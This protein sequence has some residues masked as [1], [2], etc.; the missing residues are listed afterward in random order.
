MDI[1]T[2]ATIVS[3]GSSLL[4]GSAASD[5]AKA[6]AKAI[7]KAA[8]E[9]AKISRYDSAV[10]EKDAQAIYNRTVAEFEQHYSN[11]NKL[12]SVQKTKYAKSG[13]S[14]GEGSPM[15]V[16]A[17][18]AKRGYLDGQTLLN[19]GK[20]AVERKKSLAQRYEM[21]ADAGLRDAAA[22]ASNIRDAGADQ[23]LSYNLQAVGTALDYAI[24]EEWF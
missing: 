17:N 21:L 3:V 12:I 14:I 4:G 15:D 24:S 13:V 1:G 20:N 8:K 22:A 19:N 9:N 10:A 7:K 5:Q 16:I 2:V 11:V 6:Q 18:T 23:A